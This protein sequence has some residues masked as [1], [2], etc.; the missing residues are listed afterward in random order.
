MAWITVCAASALVLYYQWE[1]WRSAKELAEA[2][3]RM[4]EYLGTDDPLKLE[5][6]KIPDDQNFYA[7]PEIESWIQPAGGEQR[8]PKYVPPLNRLMREDFIEPEVRE[9]ESDDTSAL[10]L[11][12]WMALRVKAGQPLPLNMPPALVLDRELGDGG[13]VLTRLAA[14][15][16]RPASMSKP[17]RREQAEIGMADPWEA[18][19]PHFEKFNKL[20]KTLALHLRAAALAGN[21]RKTQEVSLIMLKLAEGHST[22]ALIG[23]LVSIAGT[24]ITFSPLHQALSWPAWD[25]ASLVRLQQQL[26]RIDDLKMVDRALCVE[27]F[28]GYRQGLHWRQLK[29]AG[30][31][32]QMSRLLSGT[33]LPDPSIVRRVSDALIR[34]ACLQGP[35]G[36]ADAN[37]A[38]FVNAEMLQFGP[39]NDLAWL[40]GGEGTEAARALVKSETSWYNPRRILGAPGLPDIGNVKGSA[41]LALFK[42]RCLIIA[43]AL[44]RHRLKHGVYPVSL[45]KV[46]GGLTSFQVSDPARPGQLPGYRLEPQGYLLWS[47]GRDTRDDGGV[48]EKDWLWRM[49]RGS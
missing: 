12:G 16:D 9:D 45:E 26:E 4:F 31:V 18:D 39:R 7:C 13:G 46:K 10:D 11:A 38:F 21:A 40:R 14:A 29:A 48:A 32:D 43:C 25:D 17:G 5:P 3:R 44:E 22:H 49:K 30:D 35:V 27:M 36:W 2:Q 8:K 47:V 34:L 42:R 6:P 1:N 19:I 41:A 23:A 15:L 28:W 24:G 37:L 33:D 20:M